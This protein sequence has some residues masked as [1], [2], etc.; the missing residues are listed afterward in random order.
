M[1]YRPNSNTN[2]VIYTYIYIITYMY[3]INRTCTHK[4]DL[5][6]RPREEE[7]KERKAVNNN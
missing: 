2:N 5:Q 7:K 6:R 1:K 3:N 4:W